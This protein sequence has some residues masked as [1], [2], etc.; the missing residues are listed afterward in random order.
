MASGCSTSLSDRCK[1]FIMPIGSHQTQNTNKHHYSQWEGKDWDALLFQK[2]A[3]QVNKSVVN[4]MCITTVYHKV[5]LIDVCLS[6][7]QE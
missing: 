3:H 7:L 6:S 5:T 2:R 4:A 1:S